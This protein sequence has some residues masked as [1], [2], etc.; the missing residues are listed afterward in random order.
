MDFAS[1]LK[2]VSDDVAK[3]LRLK[4]HNETSEYVLLYGKFEKIL[5][6]RGPQLKRFLQYQEFAFG[7]E[8]DTKERRSYVQHYHNLYNDIL[9]AYLKSREQVPP[10]VLKNLRKLGTADSISEGDFEALARRSVQYVLDTCHNEQTLMF[11]FFH[12]GP[13]LTEYHGMVFWNKTANYAER[14]HD[15][16]LSHLVTLNTFLSA[17]LGHGN[18]PRIC[19]LVNWLETTYISSGDEESDADQP[20]DGRRW[21]AQVLLS[22]Y[23]WPTM[24]LLFIK[25]AG[26]IEQFK[27]SQEDLR[28]TTKYIP[29]AGERKK[30]STG[31]TATEKSDD[32]NLQAPTALNAYPTVQTAVKLL[33]MYNEGSYD[34]PV[35]L[36]GIIILSSLFVNYLPR[37]AVTSS[38]ILSTRRQNPFKRQPQ[39]SSAT[40]SLWTHNFSSSRTSCSSK[41][42]S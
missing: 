30:S 34:R 40:A 38:T 23:L 26:E 39:S 11:K 42:S 37:E 10:V 18:L 16:A 1:A 20:A 22:K 12:D 36:H 4:V 21:I 28:F 32:P 13:L 9:Q 2:E 7:R 8:Q 25:A 31:Q 33:V 6:D 14:L 24:D 27:P 29:L 3:Q 17:Y 41:T 15:N 19:Y 35:R 5:E